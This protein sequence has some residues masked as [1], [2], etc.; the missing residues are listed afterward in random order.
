L[1]TY[2]LSKEYQALLDLASES[3]N[4]EAID[5]LWNGLEGDLNAKLDGIAAVLNELDS[6]SEKLASE[7]RRLTARKRTIENNAARLKERVVW[8]LTEMGISKQ[9][10]LLH[11]FSVSKT[12][13][14]LKI[15]D[16][17]KIP[18]R[19]KLEKMEVIVLKDNLKEALK[20][21]EEIDGA[22]IEYKDSLRIK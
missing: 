6:D 14:S 8:L 22:T 13:G 4:G 3:E 9:K 5:E 12:A 15:E 21:G 18:A 7:I 11:N 2:D 17:D 16:E 1:T 20:N 10:T 19:F